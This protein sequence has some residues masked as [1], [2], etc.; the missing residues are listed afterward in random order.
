MC[1]Y[2]THNTVRYSRN[3]SAQKLREIMRERGITTR[4]LANRVN[5]SPRTIENIAGGSSSRAARQKISDYLAADIWPDIRPQ[6]S[7]GTIAEST[8]FLRLN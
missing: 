8:I 7:I 3:K 2:Y 1:D 6:T 5:L 4:E